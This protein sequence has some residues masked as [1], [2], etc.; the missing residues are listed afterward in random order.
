MKTKHNSAAPQRSLPD[1]VAI[2]DALVNERGGVARLSIV[3]LAL[4]QSLACALAADAAPNIVA[5]LSAMLPAPTAEPATD[6][7]D[8]S[9]LSDRELR[10]LEYLCR[11]AHGLKDLPKKDRQTRR[12]LDAI[13]LAK[14]LDEI[15]NSTETPKRFANERELATIKLAI[16]NLVCGA[17]R[18]ATHELWEPE[19]KSALWGPLPKPPLPDPAADGPSNK[20]GAPVNVVPMWRSIHGPGAPLARRT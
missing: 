6:N 3:Q 7:W 20:A 4:C 5:G 9:L 17:V 14:L 8:L 15:A 10:L 18:C 12:E 13:D 1:E 11:R 16:H 19:F 2:F